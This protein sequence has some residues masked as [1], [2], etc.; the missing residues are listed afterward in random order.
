MMSACGGGGGEAV[1]YGWGKNAP[2]MT[3]PEGAGFSVGPGTSIRSVVLQVMV[4][5]ASL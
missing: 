1:L 2:A 4:M 5:V 3:V